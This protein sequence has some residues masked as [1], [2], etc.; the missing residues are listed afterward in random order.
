MQMNK[1]GIHHPVLLLP[2]LGS[3]YF[4]STLEHLDQ[5]ML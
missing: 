3:S 1:V 5:K 4:E 2:D